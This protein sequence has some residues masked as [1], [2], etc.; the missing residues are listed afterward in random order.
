[1][2]YDIY[3][4]DASTEAKSLLKKKHFSMC[5]CCDFDGVMWLSACKDDGRITIHGVGYSGEG[6]DLPINHPTSVKVCTFYVA[7][8]LQHGNTVILTPDV[9]EFISLIHKYL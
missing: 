1:M 6:D 9:K 7:D 8:S 3:L 2:I 4:T 5:K